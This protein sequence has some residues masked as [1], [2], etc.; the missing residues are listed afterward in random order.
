MKYIKLFTENRRHWDAADP[1]KGELDFEEFKHLFGDISDL[2]CSCEFIDHS[3]EYSPFYDCEIGLFKFHTT[4]LPDMSMTD[5]GE[6]LP[7]CED[8]GEISSEV[9]ERAK[10][11]VEANINHLHNVKNEIDAVIEGNTTFLNVLDEITE[12]IIPRMKDYSNFDGCDIGFDAQSYDFP[13][14][15]RV[16]FEIKQN[17]F[18]K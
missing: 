3:D 17:D 7:P 1:K 15:L 4:H 9:F 2:D 16:T 10:N 11:F 13:I 5:M 14:K 6:I 8:P 18:G 12:T